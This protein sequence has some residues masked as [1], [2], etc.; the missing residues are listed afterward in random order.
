[1]SVSFAHPLFQKPPWI[2]RGGSFF[3]N[4]D[5]NP[6]CSQ[7]LIQLVSDAVLVGVQGLVQLFNKTP[8]RFLLIFVKP[9]GIFFNFLQILSEFFVFIVANGPC[10]KDTRHPEGN[11]PEDCRSH[12]HAAPRVAKY[13]SSIEVLRYLATRAA[14]SRVMCLPWKMFLACLSVSLN[15]SAIIRGVTPT[16]ASLSDISLRKRYFF[17]ITLFWTEISFLST[18]KRTFLY[19]F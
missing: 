11:D 5:L 1:M 14:D 4:H 6:P 17:F 16:A 13:T 19:F 7:S 8:V 9:I 15:V 3:S 2:P 10:T 12:A 18:P